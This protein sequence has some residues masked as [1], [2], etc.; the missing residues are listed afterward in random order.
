MIKVFQLPFM[1]YALVASSL[2]AV[3]CAFLGVFVVLRRIVFFSAVLAQ[4]STAGMA[5]GFLTGLNPTVT[6][7]ALTCATVMLFAFA[8]FGSKVPQDTILGISYVAAFAMSVL[9]ISKAAQGMEELQHLLQGNIL[10]ITTGQIYLLSITFIIIGAMHILFH[11]E[12]IFTSF[13][14]EMAETQGYAT[15]AWNVLL[16]FSIGLVVALGIRVSGT[17]LIFALL[18][19]PAAC[20]LLVLKKM[21]WIFPVAIIVS[22]VSVIFGLYFSFRFDLPS[23]PGIV[24]ILIGFL[25]LAAGARYSGLIKTPSAPA[26]KLKASG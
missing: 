3:L 15:N 4:V 13:D 17:L 8:P 14:R 20:A 26:R 23:G 10:T 21:R 12:F 22:L 9:I 16:Y 24:A 18:V 19:A 6:G 2:I 1:Q 7:L 5:L 11:K 25:L